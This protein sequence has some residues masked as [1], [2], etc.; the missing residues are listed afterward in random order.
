MAT[1]LMIYCRIDDLFHD[2]SMYFIYIYKQIKFSAK[3]HT[4]FVVWIYYERRHILHYPSIKSEPWSMPQFGVRI[5]STGS[6][7]WYHL[8]GP[9]P[10]PNFIKWVQVQNLCMGSWSG[11]YVLVYIRILCIWT[12][13]GLYASN[14]GPDSD[15]INT[16][17]GQIKDY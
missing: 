14:L 15:F 2:F 5:L 16:H 13:S 17:S 9:D 12:E 3:A 11:I 7:F 8:L 4:I 10:D 6:G 1:L